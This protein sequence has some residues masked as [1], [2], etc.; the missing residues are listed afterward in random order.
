MDDLG[1]ARERAEHPDIV[2]WFDIEPLSCQ[3]QPRN[4]VGEKPKRG[5]LKN[6][7]VVAAPDSRGDQHRTGNASDLPVSQGRHGDRPA[8]THPKDE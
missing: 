3:W 5:A 4:C 6:I 1:I 7:H 8:H 2:G